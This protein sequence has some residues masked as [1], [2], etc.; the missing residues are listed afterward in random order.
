MTPLAGPFAA[1]SLLLV[2]GGAAKV[3]NP[4]ATTAALAAASLPGRRAVVRA[5]GVA[6][7]LVG[8]GA[9]LVGGP[10]GPALVLAAYLG[11]VSFLV[12]SMRRAEGGGSCGCFGATEAPPSRIHV[13]F[14]LMAAAVAAVAG[15]TGWPGLG[16]VL[17][18]QPWGGAPL[19]GVVALLT[20]LGYLVLTLLPAV[21]TVQTAPRR[22]P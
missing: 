18:A 16:S 14:D 10:V 9:L 21:L 13:G 3:V 6:E 8:A 7:V 12:L 5:G 20:F 22:L 11:F 4:D 19:V 2:V 17:A 15:L 1:V